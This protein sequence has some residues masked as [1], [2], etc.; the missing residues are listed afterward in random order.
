LPRDRDMI[1]L[2]WAAGFFDGEGTTC[3]GHTGA[4]VSLHFVVGQKNVANLLRLQRA[5]GGIG[6]VGKPNPQGVSR[7]RAYGREAHQCLQDLW[8]FLGEEKRNQA[9]RALTAYSF[10]RVIPPGCQRGHSGP[11]YERP[12]GGRECAIC[13]EERRKGPL[14][15]VP[16]RIAATSHI[17]VREYRP[18]ETWPALAWTF[19]MPESEYVLEAQT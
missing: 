4:G 7:F 5:L 13:R 15:P 2:A 9:L 3:I 16:R 8:P 11:L 19:E 18:G 14:R 17:G 12:S 10:R 6:R 1:E